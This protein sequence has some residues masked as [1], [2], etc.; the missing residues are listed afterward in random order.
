MK[1]Y[2]LKLGLS[3]V[4]VATTADREERLLLEEGG[5]RLKTLHDIVP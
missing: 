3:W 4:Q 5:R 1:V 2:L